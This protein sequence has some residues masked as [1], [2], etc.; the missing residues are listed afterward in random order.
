M[1][2]CIYI[3]IYCYC[4]CSEACRFPLPCR[5]PPP[6]KAAPQVL[7]GQLWS[8][9]QLEQTHAHTSGLQRKAILGNH[10]ES[11]AI[12]KAQDLHS[13]H[14]C[15]APEE[16]IFTH[17]SWIHALGLAAGGRW[18]QCVEASDARPQ[19][20]VRKRVSNMDAYL[21]WMY[22]YHCL[23]RANRKAYNTNT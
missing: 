12:G 20:V 7:L 3:Y 15:C 9:Q 22:A 8:E 11:Y 1:Y 10:T 5:E 2:S 18:S 13:N 23:A 16:Y 19:Y 21:T 14:L 6:G 4:S 17:P